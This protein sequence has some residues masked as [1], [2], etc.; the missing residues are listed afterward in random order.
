VGYR[1]GFRRRRLITSLLDPNL[2]PAAELAQLYH[3]RWDIE[4]F[5]R[6]FKQSLGA[7]RWHCINPM[8]FQKELLM[9]MIALCLIRIAT[10]EAS[11]AA[12]IPAAQLS[13]SRALTETRVFLG[14]L[15]IKAAVLPYEVL[16][17]EYVR[18]CS[19]HKIQIKPN[20]QFPRNQQDYRKKSRGLQEKRKGR[21][22]VPKDHKPKTPDPE[23]MKF[24]DGLFLLS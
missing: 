13:F 24:R 15:L 6:D 8:S 4:T 11:R 9:H 12:N 5:Y 18:R 10:L 17:E 20:R 3:M 22:Y 16:W 2:F 14:R 1:N 21:K 23:I 19:R 7:T